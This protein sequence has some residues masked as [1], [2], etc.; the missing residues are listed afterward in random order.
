MTLIVL[1]V[2]LMIQIPILFILLPNITLIIDSDNIT[3]I[4][5]E[6]DTATTGTG[7]DVV[8]TICLFAPLLGTLLRKLGNALVKTSFY[9]MDDT[10]YCA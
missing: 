6:T 3:D 10:V 4:G 5:T 2:I 8:I 7:V 1:Q 9:I